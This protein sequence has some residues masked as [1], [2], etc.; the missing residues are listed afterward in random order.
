RLMT[1]RKFR[2]RPL[3]NI[4]DHVQQAESIRWKSPHRGSPD[5][6][7]SSVVAVRKSTLPGV[8]H[9]FSAGHLRI[10][11]R[12]DGGSPA[13]SG[14]FPFGFGWQPPP[15][16]ARVRHSIRIR[17]LHDRVIDPVCDSTVRTEWMLPARTRHPDP[18][19]SPI[20]QVDWTERRME[21][22]CAGVQ[23]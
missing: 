18:P 8:G 4:A 9:Q 6:A 17:H 1:G 5:P 2:G 12:I 20:V 16:P 3:P 21:Y 7:I 19:L 23:V 15:S 14:I 11:P 13:T 22:H 10:A